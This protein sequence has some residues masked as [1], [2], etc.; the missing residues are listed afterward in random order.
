MPCTASNPQASREIVME[1]FVAAKIRGSQKVE[2]FDDIVI[3]TGIAGLETARQLQGIGRSVCIIESATEIGTGATT[4]NE[5]WLHAGTYHSGAIVDRSE[6][7]KVGRLCKYGFD[8]ILEN[9][10]KAIHATDANTYAILRDACASDETTSRW[11]EADINFSPADISK[12]LERNPEL[13]LTGSEQAFHVSDLAIN[14]PVLLQLIYREIQR[15]NHRTPITFA[16]AANIVDIDPISHSMQAIHNGDVRNFRAE[17]II[18]AAGVGNRE[19]VA[20]FLG[21]PN[22]IRLFRGHIVIMPKLTPDQF[23]VLDKGSPTWMN[24][25]PY[26]IVGMTRMSEEV[27]IEDYAVNREIAGNIMASVQ[28]MILKPISAHT[29]YACLKP[30]VTDG[31]Y[32]SLAPCLLEPEMGNYLLLPGKMTETPVICEALLDK[33]LDQQLHVPVAVRPVDEL[34]QAAG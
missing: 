6:A 21:R 22:L 8:R 33:I 24:H 23:V 29:T 1:H 30:T 5:G 27:T 2:V 14:T 3:G 11:G 4:H 25:G 34:T 19:L 28:S 32:Q 7:I 9:Y 15:Q 18:Y 20:R 13:N 31:Q 16:M 10:P 26:S 12:I 17:N